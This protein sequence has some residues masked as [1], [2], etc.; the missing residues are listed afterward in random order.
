MKTNVIFRT[1]GSITWGNVTIGTWKTTNS[2]GY[3]TVCKFDGLVKLGDMIYSRRA[4]AALD[5]ERKVAKNMWVV[6][7]NGSEVVGITP[8]QFFGQR[9]VVRLYKRGEK[10][11]ALTPLYRLWASMWDHSNIEN[12]NELPDM[13]LGNH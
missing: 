9:V 2:H 4:D 8:D 3:G 11:A 6:V 7:I 12:Y 13:I 10:S 1:D 5:I